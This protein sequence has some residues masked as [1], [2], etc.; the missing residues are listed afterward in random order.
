MNDIYNMM[1]QEHD[2]SSSDS[3][4]NATYEVMQQ[5]EAIFGF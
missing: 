2:I 5:V 1:L 4:R 3:L